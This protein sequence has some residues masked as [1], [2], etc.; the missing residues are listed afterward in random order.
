MKL[1][2]PAFAALLML[3][4]Q[5]YGQ[6]EMAGHEHFIGRD[7]AW[8]V[9]RTLNPLRSARFFVYF[10]REVKDFDFLISSD[11]VNFTRLEARR[12]DYFKGSGDYDYWKPVAYDI[13]SIPRGNYFL[14]LVFRTDAQIGRVEIEHQK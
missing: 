4:S 12:R 3:S 8:L 9:Y 6:S 13:G 5:I 11:G 14:K 7:Q 2:V 10:E 1:L